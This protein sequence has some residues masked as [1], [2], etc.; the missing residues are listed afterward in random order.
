MSKKDYF[1]AFVKLAE[2]RIARNNVR[3]QLEWKISIALWAFLA[4]AI[5][6]LKIRPSDYILVAALALIVIVHGGMWV[7][8]IWSTNKYDLRA[9]FHY[10]NCAEQALLEVPF[11][12]EPQ[13][14]AIAE[15]EQG[16]VWWYDLILSDWSSAIQIFTTIALCTLA[17]FLI[18]TEYIHRPQSPNWKVIQSE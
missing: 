6:S 18:A 7:A 11:T 12:F 10:L 13:T 3:R 8:K 4:A 16:R 5:Y 15:R 1:D 2:V 9:A 14:K 17:Y